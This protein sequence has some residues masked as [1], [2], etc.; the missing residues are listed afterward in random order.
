MSETIV[1]HYLDLGRLGR[2]EVVKSVSYE[3]LF[4]EP[5]LAGQVR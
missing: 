4:R 2:G 1:Y 5:S 3:Y